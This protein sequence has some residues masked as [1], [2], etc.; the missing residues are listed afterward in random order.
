MASSSR[1]RRLQR[2]VVFELT[3]KGADATAFPVLREFGVESLVELLLDPPEPSTDLEGEICSRA[4][5][6]HQHSYPAEIWTEEV[7]RRADGPGNDEDLEM[8]DS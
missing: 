3:V 6:Y 2:S 8:L 7:A 4:S 1:F 5:G